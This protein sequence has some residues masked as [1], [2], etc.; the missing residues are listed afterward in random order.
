MIKIKRKKNAFADILQKYRYIINNGDIIAGTIVQ[1]ESCGFV[2][3]IGTHIAGYLPQEEV[4][5]QSSKYIQDYMLLINNT[6]EFFVITQNNK[7]QQP[8]LSIKRIEYIRAW[9]R[10]KQMYMEDAIIKVKIKYSNKGGMVTYLE[11]IQ[12]FI[13]QSEFP[14]KFNR[15]TIK[16]YIS[17]KIINLND[18]KNQI[19]LSNKSTLIILSKHNFKLG[20]ILYGKIS[21]IKSYGFF[22]EIYN[23]KALLHISEIAHKLIVNKETFLS[24]GKIIKVKIIHINIKKGQ[25]SVSR[26]NLK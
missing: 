9:K 1:K 24:I 14:I 11:N 13:P 26:R 20:E 19:I 22:L 12:G 3:N 8:I 15:N 23:I 25:L 4:Q 5:L 7:N 16:N 6:R 18:Q 10:I 17:C 21:M 2:V